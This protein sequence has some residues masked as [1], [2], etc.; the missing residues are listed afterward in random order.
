MKNQYNNSGYS[1]SELSNMGLQQQLNNISNQQQ[2][3]Q[4]LEDQ[5]Q[6][7][8]QNMMQAVSMAQVHQLMKFYATMCFTDLGTLNLLSFDFKLKPIFATAPAVSKFNA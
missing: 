6:Q 5:Q 2:Q 3:Q 8:Q 1:K 7:Q 4:Q